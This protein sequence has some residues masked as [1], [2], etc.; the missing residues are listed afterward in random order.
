MDS[1]R[2]REEYLTYQDRLRI[3]FLVERGKVIR[4]DLV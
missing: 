4:I 3:K 1:I 2:E